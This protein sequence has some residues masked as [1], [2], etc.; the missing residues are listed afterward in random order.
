MPNIWFNT[1]PIIVDIIPPTRN[2][3]EIIEKI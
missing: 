2:E 3:E 1:K